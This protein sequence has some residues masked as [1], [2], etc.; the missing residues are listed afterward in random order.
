M[1]TITLSVLA[2]VLLAGAL[3]ATAASAAPTCLRTRDIVGSTSKDGHALDFTMRDGTTIRNHLQGNCSDL[4]FE[5]FVWVIRGP[6]E[7]CE[8]QQSL[9]VIN[10]GQVCTLGMFDPPVSRMKPAG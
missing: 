10:S 3:S 4:K 8:K 2:G 1:K 9:R 5:G 7:V 6:D